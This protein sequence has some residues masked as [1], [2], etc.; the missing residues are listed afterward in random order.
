[1]SLAVVIPCY[2]LGP[3]VERAV[4]SALA[5]SRS[6]AD[7]E[8]IV[9]DDGSDDDA[10]HAA[11][12]RCEALGPSVRVLR[13]RVNQ[14]AA[15]ARNTGIGATAARWIAFLD[16][17]DELVPCGLA[18]RL[19]HGLGHGVEWVAGDFVRVSD[20]G[21]PAMEPF[22]R[23]SRATYAI[24]AEAYDRGQPVRWPAPVTRPF[25]EPFPFLTS[26]V[27]VRRDVL[28]DVG[29]FAQELRR[30]QDTHLWHRISRR[31]GGFVFV[32]EV[33]A[34]YTARRGSLSRSGPPSVGRAQVLRLLLADPAFAALR[35]QIRRGLAEAR[36]R[37]IRYWRRE[38]SWRAAAGECLAWCRESPLS[39]APWTQLAAVVLRRP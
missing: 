15:A 31:G 38:R 30:A 21:E 23:A 17:D 25:E 26:T 8:I 18:R 20:D 9:I 1:M 34:R 11:L 4:R 12:E 7:V 14:G 27:M 29:G 33:V 28:I 22:L 19:E 3:L 39:P 36:A 16:G 13:H 5:A 37:N 24:A 6:L 10:T 35:S 2:R 32:P